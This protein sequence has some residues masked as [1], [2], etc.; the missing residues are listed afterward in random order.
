MLFIV[1][2]FPSRVW[3]QDKRRMGQAKRTHQR[4]MVVFLMGALALHP[5]YIITLVIAARI[6]AEGPI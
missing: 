4:F 5:S 2:A 3:E 6:V 1:I